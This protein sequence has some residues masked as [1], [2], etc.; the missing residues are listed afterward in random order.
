Q[1]GPDGWARA[2]PGGALDLPLE[3][4]DVLRRAVL[5]ER[6]GCPAA[7][8]LRRALAEAPRRAPKPRGAAPRPSPPGAADPTLL[9]LLWVIVVFLGL[10]A[11]AL[12]A[13]VAVLARR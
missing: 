13:L 8:A 9:Q 1:L 10:I 4:V 7:E 3:V 5:Y 12:W 11:G 6:E 2:A